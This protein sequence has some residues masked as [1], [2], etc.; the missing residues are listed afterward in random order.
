MSG[1]L[2]DGPGFNG[3]PNCACCRALVAVLAVRWL[4]LCESIEV[5]G[6]QRLKHRR[7]DAVTEAVEQ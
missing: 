4:V 3:E 7:G 5:Q 2:L 1:F 6:D